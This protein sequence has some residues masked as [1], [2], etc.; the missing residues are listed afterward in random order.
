MDQADFKVDFIGVG[1][2][3]TASSWIFQCLDEHPQICGARPKETLFF[4]TTKL[5][6]EPLRSRSAYEEKGLS[7]Y[8]NYFSHCPPNLI[9]GEFTTTY[10]HDKRVAKFIHETFPNAKIL[11]SLRDPIDRV[12]SQYLAVRHLNLFRNFEDALRCEPEFIRRSFYAE[13]VGEYFKFFPSEKILIVFYEDILDDAIKFIQNI[14]QFLEVDSQFVPP[15]IQVKK[16]SAEEKFLA[17][18]HS[19]MMTSACGRMAIRLG[20]STKINSVLKRGVMSLFRKPAM[21]QETKNYLKGMF[22]E[23][24]ENLESLLGRDCTFWKNMAPEIP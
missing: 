8:G 7:F 10:L 17:K 12:Y 21:N 1:G 14:Y 24:M 13:Y 6:G 2:E 23:D 15:G 5:I 22:K 11:I 16:R 19:N 9:K 3:K 20:R 4:D 18:L